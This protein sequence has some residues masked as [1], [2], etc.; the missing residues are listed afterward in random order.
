MAARPRRA[1]PEGMRFSLRGSSAFS[2]L[3]APSKRE[4]YLAEYVI[5]EHK[6]GRSLEDVL[7]DPYVRNRSTPDQRARVLERPDVIEAKNMIGMTMRYQDR[8]EVF[9]T[10]TQSLLPKITRSIH[11]YCLARVLD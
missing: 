7:D 9:Q 6:Q 1:H 2:F 4:Q 3:F 5:R 10:D 11:D 8:I